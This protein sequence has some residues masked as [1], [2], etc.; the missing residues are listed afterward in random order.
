MPHIYRVELIDLREADDAGLEAISQ[1]WQLAL[2]L[3]EMQAIQT[4]YQ[5]EGRA[6]TD[7]ELKMLAQTWSEHYVHMTFKA[8]IDYTGPNGEQQM[9][10]GLF[11]TYIRAATEQ[12]NK[13][14]V[15]SAFVGH[16]VIL[17][18][19]LYPTNVQMGDLIVAIGGRTG[20]D[21]LRR[22]TGTSEIAGNGR[23]N[24]QAAY[25]KTSSGSGASRP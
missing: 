17:P 24:W 8:I 7:A 19:D 11:D 5:Q 6:A 10:N 22:D 16:A 13:P 4:Y 20:W 2:N 14:W 1:E 18:H 15:R 25:G 9:I 23:S 21:G 3:Q 12:I